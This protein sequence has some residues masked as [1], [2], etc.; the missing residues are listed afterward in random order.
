MK[1]LLSILLTLLLLASCSQ[2]EYLNDIL[3]YVCQNGDIT[4]ATM[5][6]EPFS[7]IPWQPVFHERLSALVKYVDTIHTVIEA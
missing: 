4:R 7:S 5:G 1:K 2:E 3:D 6:Q